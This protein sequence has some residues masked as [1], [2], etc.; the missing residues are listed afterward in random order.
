MTGTNHGMTGAVIALLVKEPLLAVPLSFVSH[1][2]C[3][4]IPHAGLAADDKLF[5]KKFNITLGCD[6]L[7]ALVMMAV[8]GILFPAQKWLVW[9]CM[10]AAAS[11]D[12]MWAYY[13]LYIEKLKNKKPQFGPL[14]RFHIWIQWSETPKGWFIEILWFIGVWAIV[15][16]QR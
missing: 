10:V 14:A 7:F 8:L 1:F 6:F 12:L 2:V 13:E 3:D 16:T 9:A 11:P 15:L 5:D 4:S